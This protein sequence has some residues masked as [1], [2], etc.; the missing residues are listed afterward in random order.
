MYR[1][2]RVDAKTEVRGLYAQL[3]SYGEYKPADVLVP[4]S[5]M[6][7]GDAQALDVAITDPTGKV[8]VQRLSHRQPLKAA[9]IRHKDKMST[10]RKARSSRGKWPAI[11]QS[12]AGVRDHGRHGHG[13][14]EVVEGD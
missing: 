11:H 1:S 14:P 7:A 10:H 2:L 6:G 8:A 12:T 9:E 5:A 4:A 13:D 3:T